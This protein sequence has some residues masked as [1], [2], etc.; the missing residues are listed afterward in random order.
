MAFTADLLRKGFHSSTVT[1]VALDIRHPDPGQLGPFCRLHVEGRVPSAA[2]VY[3]WV[4]NDRVMYVGKANEL[5]QIVRGARMQRAYNDYNLHSA[6]QG[7]A[8]P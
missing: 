7:A 4:V 3:A 1:A 8:G 5:C 6:I 2:G